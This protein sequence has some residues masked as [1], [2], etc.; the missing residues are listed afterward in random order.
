MHAYSARTNT[1]TH[2]HTPLLTFNLHVE[3]L[4]GEAL[5]CGGGG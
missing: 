1:N 2:M 3:V 4:Q 5:L